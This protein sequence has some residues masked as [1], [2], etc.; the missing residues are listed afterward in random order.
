MKVNKEPKTKTMIISIIP[1]NSS[2]NKTCIT[3]FKV[4]IVNKGVIKR[5]RNKIWRWGTKKTFDFF[6]WKN[7]GWVRLLY[8]I[9]YI[10]DIHFSV[11]SIQCMYIFLGLFLNI[12]KETK[13]F[14]S[15]CD[16]LY[17]L[18]ILLLVVNVLNN[19]VI[20]MIKV[21]VSQQIYI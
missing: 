1:H 13:I 9:L 14:L 17:K 16:R 18:Y 20:L 12:A 11:W 5:L 19:F 15:I 6:N 2:V 10:L 8:N 21:I 7:R 3:F 4:E